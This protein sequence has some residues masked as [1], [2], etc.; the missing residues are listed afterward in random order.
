LG[1]QNFH[2]SWLVIFLLSSVWKVSLYSFGAFFVR[3][4][5]SSGPR[6]ILFWCTFMLS[7]NNEQ[8]MDKEDD[9]KKKKKKQQP[10]SKVILFN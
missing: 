9:F 2:T 6:R 4:Q 5:E 10:W 1:I 7:N 8:V 3:V